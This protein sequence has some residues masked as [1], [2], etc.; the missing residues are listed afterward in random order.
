MDN[1]KEGIN[2]LKGYQ[3]VADFQRFCGVEIVEVEIDGEDNNIGNGLNNSEEK[4][5]ENHQNGGTQNNVKKRSAQSQ[6]NGYK[7]GISNPYS[8]EA[9]LA[10]KISNK[11]LYYLFQFGAGLGS[12]I[13]YIIFFPFMTWNVDSRLTRQMLLIW[14]PL[15]YF[16]QF[17]KDWIQWPRPGPPAVRLEGNRFEMEYGMPSTHTIVGTCI[18]FS[19]LVLTSKYYEVFI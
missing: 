6:M 16:G 7:N 2:Y 19:L 8:K 3:H 12:E 9:K 13:F 4:P 5:V 15:M 18:P 1:F 10:Y 14:Y 17:L 11:V